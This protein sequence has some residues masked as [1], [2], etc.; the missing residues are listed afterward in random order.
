MSDTRPPRPQY[1]EYASPEQ[2][3]AAM[4]TVPVAAP[5]APPT[6]VAVTTAPAATAVA[7]KRTTAR[8]WD[9]LLSFALLAY[10]LYSV[11]SGFFQYRDVGALI[12][13]V[14]KIQ[15]VG[16]YT[17]TPLTGQLGIVIIVVQV[18]LYL[19]ALLLTIARLR[20]GKI[21]FWIPLTAGIVAGLTSAICLMVLV[22]GDPAFTAY[23]NTLG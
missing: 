18:V 8:P 2:Q 9:N 5:A 23:L 21:A 4:G 16:D 7:A 10:G 13:Q 19:A 6:T 14:Y 11:V 3:A 17:V 15:G 1:G 22:T 12:N 20:A